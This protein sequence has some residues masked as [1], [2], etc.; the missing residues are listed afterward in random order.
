MTQK[1]FSPFSPKSS[2]NHIKLSEEVRNDV[3][4]W[5]RVFL[6]LDYFLS[7]GNINNQ[8]SDI[9]L[10]KSQ[11][12]H[13][14]KIW[15][16]NFQGTLFLYE[17]SEKNGPESI[18]WPP[19]S[20]MGGFYRYCLLN[21]YEEWL[22]AIIYWNSCQECREKFTY[23]D[24]LKK[25][26]KNTHINQKPYACDVCSRKYFT[27]NELKQHYKKHETERPFECDLCEKSY[28]NAFSLKTHKFSHT[29]ERPYLCRV[30]GKGFKTSSEE[31]LHLK[32]HTGERPHKC[33]RCEK[34]FKT[35][36]ELRTHIRRHLG[37]KRFKCDTCSKMFYTSSKMKDH[38]KVHKIY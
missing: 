33:D 12:P 26:Y 14:L 6:V 10:A 25:H 23:L 2:H 9:F 4:N 1:F 15:A 34:R 31:S 32:T 8:I 36:G 29:G 35:L 3:Y 7:F 24:S 20:N 13:L 17:E 11:K 5:F 22:N 30:C 19:D 21:N 16:E 38:Q 18:C 37:D 28:K 27:S